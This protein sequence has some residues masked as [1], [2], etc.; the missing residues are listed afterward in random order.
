MLLLSKLTTVDIRLRLLQAADC[1]IYACS[2]SEKDDPVLCR[3]KMQ[4]VVIPEVDELLN[5]DIVPP[6]PYNRTLEQGL[7]D[8]LAVLHT[9]GSSG[10]DGFPKVSPSGSLQQRDR[11]SHSTG[12]AHSV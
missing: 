11:A 3:R 6:Y 12:T 4:M 5:P 10:K 2:K 9:S 7:N 1:H 8:P